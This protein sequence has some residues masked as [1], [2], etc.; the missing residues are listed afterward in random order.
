M[1]STRRRRHTTGVVTAADVTHIAAT[2]SP[3]LAGADGDVVQEETYTDLARDE[4]GGP[5]Q[6]NADLRDDEDGTGS[7]HFTL[8]PL[9][10]VV[11]TASVPVTDP[12]SGQSEATWTVTPPAT[13]YTGYLAETEAG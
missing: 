10:D 12:A 13:D 1:R 6:V 7:V 4:P 8:R 3:A 5:V 11:Q 2:A 9:G